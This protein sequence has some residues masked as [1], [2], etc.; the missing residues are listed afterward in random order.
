MALA[1]L[2]VPLACTMQDG[3]TQARAAAHHKASEVWRDVSLAPLLLIQQSAHLGT[4]GARRA[5]QLQHSCAVCKHLPRP[6]RNQAACHAGMVSAAG[7]GRWL[8]HPAPL[9]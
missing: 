8:Q 9:S 2:T 4:A 5:H 7:A 6:H 3:I 1:A